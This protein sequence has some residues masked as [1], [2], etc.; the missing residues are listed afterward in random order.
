MRLPV[1]LPIALL[2][3]LSGC[4][5]PTAD[6]DVAPVPKDTKTYFKLA[7][8]R[9]DRTK[10]LTVNLYLNKDDYRNDRNIVKTFVFPGESDSLEVKLDNDI[11]YYY[12]M[13]SEDGTT[14]NWALWPYSNN[15]F[16]TN[17]HA[18][19]YLI[20]GNANEIHRNLL[21]PDNMQSKW[22]A[23]GSFTKAGNSWDTMSAAGRNKS[24][25]FMKSQTAIYKDGANTREFRFGVS[26][27]NIAKNAIAIKLYDTEDLDFIDPQYHKPYMTCNGPI[28]PQ[29]NALSPYS[30]NSNVVLPVTDTLYLTSNAF[31][32]TFI[33]VREK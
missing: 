26:G 7:F 31:K 14:T 18:R 13:Y 24:I 1:T 8:G 20:G 9:Q 17:S 19:E 2:W 15:F 23:V 30:Q 5:K 32:H 12:D 3:L 21:L 4:V 25:V 16:K 29:Y 33:L 11:T 27:N 6:A 28:S 10:A 22:V